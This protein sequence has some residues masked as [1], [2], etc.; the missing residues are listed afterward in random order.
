LRL[1]AAADFIAAFLLIRYEFGDVELG[2]GGEHLALEVRYDLAIGLFL[3]L[4]NELA[5][6]GKLF[7]P[8]GVEG[9][10][11]LVES[12]LMGDLIAEIDR[13]SGGRLAG[14][15]RGERFTLETQSSVF[16]PTSLAALSNIPSSL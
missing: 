16:E 5:F 10:E 13:E 6:L 2:H 1:D 11:G 4:R 14:F 12:P 3:L 7:F 15:G 9:R 8:Q